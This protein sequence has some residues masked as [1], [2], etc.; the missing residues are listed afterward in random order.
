[1]PWSVWSSA[2][3]PSVG[4]PKLE[5]Q[6]ICAQRTCPLA[7]VHLLATVFRSGQHAS[8][9]VLL[10]WAKAQLVVDPVPVRSRSGKVEVVKNTSE[11]EPHL[12]VRQAVL[13]VSTTAKKSLIEQVSPLSKTTARPYREGLHQLQLIGGIL[14][15]SG[16]SLRYKG[17]GIAEGRLET[18]CCTLRYATK[19][20]RRLSAETVMR[21][22]IRPL[23]PVAPTR[24]QSAVPRAQRCIDAILLEPAKTGEETRITLLSG[25]QA[26]QVCRCPRHHLAKAA[27]PG[28]ET[29][30]RIA[31]ST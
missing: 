6:L 24:Q 27:D 13:V 29:V 1:M 4:L 10:P 9:T 15:I 28:R 30:V 31:V 12:H 5:I 7:K 23:T 3:T 18:V 16:P 20:L 11:D 8:S 26:Y 19:C 21:L 14:G 2:R 25:T 17:I 22:H